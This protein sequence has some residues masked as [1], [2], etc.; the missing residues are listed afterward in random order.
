M[1][2]IGILV[3]LYSFLYLS[4]L[5]NLKKKLVF[6]CLINNNTPNIPTNDEIVSFRPRNGFYKFLLP[7]FGSSFSVQREQYP[8]VSSAAIKVI[9]DFLHSQLNLA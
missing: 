1:S 8:L 3:N 6:G 2:Q 9:T 5:G 4:Y 7:D